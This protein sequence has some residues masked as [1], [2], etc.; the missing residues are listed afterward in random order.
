M[1]GI[2]NAVAVHL[3]DRDEAV[4]LD[5]GGSGHSPAVL[6]HVIWS[7]ADVFA[8]IERVEG[9]RTDAA[10]AVRDERV[11]TD[12][13]EVLRGIDRECPALLGDED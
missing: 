4:E 2:E 3:T 11:D 13:G 5:A 1:L 9:S 10:K 12:R 7:V 6:T 8:E